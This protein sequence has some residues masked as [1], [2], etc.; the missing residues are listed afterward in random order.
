MSN[1]NRKRLKRWAAASLMVAAG[2]VLTPTLAQASCFTNKAIC[3]AICG[4]DCCDG[5]SGGTLK[6]PGAVETMN[7]ADLV[8]EIG[9]AK[10]GS[11][12]EKALQTEV[13]RRSL[14]GASPP[15]GVL[16]PVGASPPN[17]TPSAAGRSTTEAILKKSVEPV[18]Q[19]RG[20]R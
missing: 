20:Q 3:Q 14:V 1:E 19:G 4:S 7:K 13:D 8:A 6:N 17:T 11:E 12:F 5:W 18:R 15:N 9:R 2:L 16:P 10:E